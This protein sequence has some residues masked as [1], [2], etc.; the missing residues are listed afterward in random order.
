VLTLHPTTSRDRSSPAWST[1]EERPRTTVQPGGTGITERTAEMDRPRKTR[2]WHSPGSFRFQ[3][4]H[5]DGQ[6]IERRRTALSRR[7]C[8]IL[9]RAGAVCRGIGSLQRPT[10]AGVAMRWTNSS[11]LPSGYFTMRSTASCTS[12]VANGSRLCGIGRATKA[13]GI[14]KERTCRRTCGTCNAGAET[15]KP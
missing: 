2:G 3:S 10:K 6:R 4:A 7:H 5:D 12:L 14:V 1:P 11:F 13:N 8:S 15:L 9:I